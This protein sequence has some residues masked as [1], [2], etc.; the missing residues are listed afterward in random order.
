MRKIFIFQ[1]LDYRR[2]GI[3][4]LCHGLFKHAVHIQAH[5]VIAGRP[6]QGIISEKAADMGIADQRCIFVGGAWRLC[7][8]LLC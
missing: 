7:L 8:D 1:K 2:L 5:T 6:R 4:A 3:I